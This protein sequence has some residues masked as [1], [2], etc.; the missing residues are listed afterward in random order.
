MVTRMRNTVYFLSRA[1]LAVLVVFAG[2]GLSTCDLLTQSVFP[3]HLP[4]V[5]K[6][7]DLSD[8]LKDI[9]RR[10][11]EFRIMPLY[12]LD[13]ATGI[14]NEYIFILANP[15]SSSKGRLGIVL[16]TELELRLRAWETDLPL[17]ADFWFDD[18]VLDLPTGEFLIGNVIVNASATGA[19]VT[20]SP[21]WGV[22]RSG[23]GR[24][25][26][27]AGFSYVKQFY[28]TDSG[29]VGTVEDPVFEFSLLNDEFTYDEG[30]KNFANV[31]LQQTILFHTRSSWTMYHP[32]VA[33]GLP[34]RGP[35]GSSVGPRLVLLEDDGANELRGVYFD[36]GDAAATEPLST[37]RITENVSGMYHITRSGFIAEGDNDTLVRYNDRGKEDSRYETNRKKSEYQYYGFSV[38]EK[39]FYLFDSDTFELHK[40]RTWW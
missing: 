21:P 28:V 15:R 16:D 10:D 38:F 4:Y 33:G 20:A 9:P 13:H 27:G 6:V 26:G 23:L 12:S 30:T 8:L 14:G 7:T 40:L 37:F 34:R 18:N 19:E 22:G 35:D 17:G 31:G 32:K 2:L 1:A 29:N 24:Y 3:G 25:D 36:I 39:Y 5:A 11:T